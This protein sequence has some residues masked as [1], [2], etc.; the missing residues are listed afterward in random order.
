MRL[1]DLI[2]TSC[3]CCVA[4]STNTQDIIEISDSAMTDKVRGAWAG[5]MI[6]VMYGRP[7]EFLVSDRMYTDSVVWHPENVAGALNEDDLYG[8]MNFMATMQRLGQDAPLDSLARC[9]A[10]ADFDLCHANL[11]ARK[12]YF[13]GLRGKDISSPANNIH[14]EDIDF[15][16]ECDFIGFINPAMPR[17]A[18][19]MCDRVG[20]VMAAADGLY[21]G[22]F[23]STLH[24][25]S[26]TSSDIEYV[27]DESLKS[28]PEESAYSQCIRDV[29]AAY[30][31]DPEDW[32]ECWTIIN[33]KWNE[34]D[35]CTP[36]HTFNI[37]AKINGAYVVMGLLYGGGDMK[38]TMDITVGCGQDTD[39][40]TATAA[41]V[42][43]L[44]K[45]FSGIPDEFKSGIA[46]IADQKFVFTD[47]SF[48]DAVDVTLGF[49]KE[50]VVAGGGEYIPDSLYR[51]AAQQPVQ[52]PLEDGL[53]G[54]VMAEQVSITDSSRWQLNGQWEPFVYGNG[55]DAPY[56]VATRPGDSASITFEGSG[57]ALLGSWNID[58][59]RAE[60]TVDD[61]APVKIETYYIK[62]AGKF[63]GNRA[64]LY[65]ISGLPS[66]K[67]SLS[68]VN[69][70]EEATNSSG[71]KIY[72]E[73]ALIYK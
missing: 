54:L 44:M 64:Y 24:S 62:E 45:G 43:G 63:E 48:N 21:A 51:I 28:I 61:M 15:Q 29:I 32:T 8:Q 11:Q 7:M 46:A 10:E 19:E 5:K 4:C 67:H 69:L 41:A 13:D 40:N 6:G 72:L 37:D 17:S 18:S 16:I 57:I 25:L 52:A 53:S 42:L 14:C 9:F 58:G 56:L 65:Y 34:H 49:I 23:V 38:K 36:Y 12:N 50:N 33:R 20:R 55:D 22:I 70:P 73:R 66:G 39:C 31:A 1:T 3:L 68:L 30:K 35:I 27:I 60:V 26:Y 71:N 47:Y 59:G 2:I